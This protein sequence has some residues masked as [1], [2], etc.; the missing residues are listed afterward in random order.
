MIEFIDGNASIYADKICVIHNGIDVASY[1]MLGLTTHPM[2]NVKTILMVGA[3]RWEK[4]QKTVIRS[5]EHLEEMY[6]IWFVGGGDENLMKECKNLTQE[7]GLES[8]V[9]FL[10]VR[11]DVVE[12]M[13]QV[14]V[15]VQS[16]HIDGFCLAAVEGM[17]SGLPVVVSD[18]P[19]VGDI[20]RGAGVLFPHEDARAL[21]HAIK[22]LCED[23]AYAK[24]IANKCQQRAKMFDIAVMA[25]RYME[26]YSYCK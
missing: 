4:D 17:A 18:I 19:G 14:D 5:L 13:H 12:L 24:D 25:Q 11:S 3:F 23:E 6:R 7:L 21:A 16:S 15:L 10:G 1:S 22:Q 9:D 26:L 8:R 2:P 20:V